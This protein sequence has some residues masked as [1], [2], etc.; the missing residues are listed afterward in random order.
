MAGGCFLT[1]CIIA[2]L[3][4]GILAGDAMKGVLIGTAVGALLALT[5][6]LVDRMR[7]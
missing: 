2:G 5:I 7:D 4:G 1:V 3:A 6:W